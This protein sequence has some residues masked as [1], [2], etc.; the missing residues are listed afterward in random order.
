MPEL[1]IDIKNLPAAILKEVR[2]NRERAL[3]ALRRAARI[4]EGVMVDKSDASD[5]RGTFRQGWSVEDTPDGAILGNDAP[6]AQ[7]VEEG[8]RPF[9][10]R[11]YPVFAYLYRKISGTAGVPPGVAP[12]SEKYDLSDQ[13]VFQKSS[14]T[15]DA[16]LDQIRRRALSLAGK[17]ARDGIAPHHVLSEAQPELE[18]IA[19][20]ELA[21]AFPP[22]GE[23]AAP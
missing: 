5:D 11:F 20:E 21:R 12:N 17:I 6:H 2:D 18:T 22:S 4:A 10:P 1:L 16:P 19:G 15:Y 23:G 9:W 3:S 8:T 13:H 14:A 7:I